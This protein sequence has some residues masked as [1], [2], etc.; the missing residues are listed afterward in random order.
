MTVTE[1]ICAA[2][3]IVAGSAA[4][5]MVAGHPI[6]VVRIDDDFYAIGDICS[7]QKISLSEGDVHPDEGELECWKHGSSFSLTT[8]EPNSLPATKAVP[9]YT[10][11]RK[12]DDLFV[13]VSA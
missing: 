6:A 9:V 13:E 1:R 2:D 5:F 7:H 10:V 11:T 4:R 3:D 8:G 12:G